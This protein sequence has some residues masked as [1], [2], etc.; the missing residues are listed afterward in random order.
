MCTYLLEGF[1]FLEVRQNAGTKMLSLA[2]KHSQDSMQ[3]KAV[4]IFS[5]LPL[6]GQTLAEE[7][8][9]RC[10]QCQA[11][12]SRNGCFKKRALQELHIQGF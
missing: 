9:H 6:E 3:I 12:A 11:Q 7:Y 1:L 4:K 10:M 2:G 5:L 8:E